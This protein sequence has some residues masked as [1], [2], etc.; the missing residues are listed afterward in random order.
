[1]RRISLI[2]VL[3][4]LVIGV[5]GCGGGGDVAETPPP[6]PVAAPQTTPPSPDATA[7]DPTAA[8]PAGTETAQTP[9]ADQAL[10]VPAPPG[11]LPPEL[12]ASTNPNQRLQQIQTNRPDPFNRVTVQA[13]V[14]PLENANTAAAPQ[15]TGSPA[16]L[17]SNRLAPVPN[18]VGNGPAQP[19]SRPI[20]PP[21]PQPSLA[22]AVQVLGVV[23]IGRVPHAIVQAPNEPHSRYVRVGD[24]LSNGEVLVKRIDMRGS[25]P[26]VVLEQIGI[27]VSLSVG[28]GGVPA[29]AEST[30]TAALPVIPV[31]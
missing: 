27:E 15:N 4:I 1:M 17:D 22:R 23:Q 5:T 25:E 9:G 12:I 19:P 2:T 24:R 16:Q 10:P 31:N 11:S 8:A 30:T 6:D 18:L 3:G 14:E 7:S 21:P 28:S 20:P 13:R 29:G 26:Q